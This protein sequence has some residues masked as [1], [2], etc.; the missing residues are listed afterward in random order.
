MPDESKSQDDLL[1]SYNLGETAGSLTL[2]KLLIKALE[3]FG[4]DTISIREKDF[5]I[6][7]EY[8][9]QTYYECARNLSLGLM[10]LGL[11]KGERV[12]IISQNR[13]EWLYAELAT[14]AIRAI[15]TGIP[16]D[17]LANETQYI[18]NHC[19]AKIIFAE[20][21]EQ[22]DKCLLREEEFLPTVEWIIYDDPNGMR[23]YKNPHIISLKT[24]LTQG[25]KIYQG[26]QQQFLTM[27]GEGSIE[28]I[29]L[30]SYTSGTTGLPKGVIITHKNLIYNSAALLALDKMDREDNFL[31][32]IP[33]PYLGEQTLGVACH[34]LS[35]FIYNLPEEPETA[36]ANV[37]EIGPSSVLFLPRVWEALCSEVQVK[38]SDTIALKRL[39]FNL[40]VRIGR[41]YASLEMSST[42]SPWWIKVAYFWAR[43]ISLN[44]VLDKMG[45]SRLKRA[46]TVG[47]AIGPEIFLFFRA[48]GINLKQTYG[49][50]EVSGL[51]CVQPNEEANA[52]T[53]GRPL[54][55]VQIDVV[56]N[57]EICI[58][59]PG[60]FQG[61]LK[62]PEATEAVL[63]D[64]W[65]HSGDAGYMDERRHLIVIDRIKDLLMLS[66]GTLFSPQYIENKLK[67]SP[68][69]KDAVV[70]GQNRPFLVV[71]ISLDMGNMEKWCENNHISFTTY[72]DLSQK[73]EIYDL[74]CKEVV[75]L[76]K[77]L[78]ESAQIK[79]FSILYKELDADD[80]ELTRTKKVRRNIV[81]KRYTEIIESMYSRK[82]EV[83]TSA[84]VKFEGGIDKTIYIQ[85]KIREIEPL[86]K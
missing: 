6:W 2:P 64:G 77:D 86:E 62:N 39:A 63:R 12:A 54:P 1:K 69:I 44:S 50:A 79:Y 85:V 73:D 20:D 34:L 52:H 55:G 33:L 58:R 29:A 31:S 30:I 67:F 15:P 51:C 74:I 83:K 72:S 4:R 27:I 17:S 7:M 10:D 61:Y 66:D 24:V 19:E 84:K 37:R 49:I 14:Q 26:D 22:V 53:S 56:D 65:Y 78:P 46:Y 9:W 42:V 38:I 68:Y 35:G 75:A 48:L 8:T 70:I 11:K 71:L 57:Q 45:F 25:E 28:D 82:K 13:P 43:L 81:D 3:R 32:M 40:G 23:K 76:T 41:Q 5:G 36:M 59:G 21:Q 47:A 16:P 18:I 60:V 80:E